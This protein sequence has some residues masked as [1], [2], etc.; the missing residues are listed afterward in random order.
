MKYDSNGNVLW[1]NSAGGNG[2]EYSNGIATDFSGNVCITG[3]FDSPLLAFGSTT[4]MA[5]SEDI[6]VTK[7]DANGNV[8]W[9]KAAGGSNAEYGSSVSIDSNNDIYISGTFDS[10]NLIFGTTTLTCLGGE[11]SYFTKYDSN[12]S[13]IWAKK[14]GGLGNDWIDNTAVDAGGNL[15]LVGTFSSNTLTIGASTFTNSGAFDGFVVKYDGSGNALWAKKTGGNSTDRVYSICSDLSSN[16]Y[17]TGSF[18]SSSFA[19]GSTTL[20]SSSSTELFEAQFDP[21]GNAIWAKAATGTDADEGF[22]IAT[23]VAGNVYTT[24]YYRS[25]TIN[26]GSMSCSNSGTT[27][28]YIAKSGSTMG[29]NEIRQLENILFSPNPFSDQ[30]ILKSKKYYKNATL[31]LFNSLGQIASEI[32]NIE[33]NTITVSRN[34]LLEGVYFALLSEENIIISRTKIIISNK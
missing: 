16:L 26:F 14:I 3:W 33:G 30:T 2:S 9:A 18:A 8:L 5:S 20:T 7:Y 17:I 29:N 1:A 10:P 12:G 32:N 34:N 28:I 22:G 6:F 24:G 19:I 4:L 23:D 27:N 11:D 21:S 13:I 25:P 31:T 15:C